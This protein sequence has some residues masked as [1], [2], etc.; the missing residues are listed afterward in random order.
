MSMNNKSLIALDLDGT[1]LKDD[2]TIS[3]KTKTYLK[4]LEEQGNLIVLCSGRALRSVSKYY[5]DIG[6]KVSPIIAYNGHYSTNFH[7][8][9]YEIVHKIDKNTA[10]SLYSNLI[11]G[12]IISAT[13][14]NMHTIYLDKDDPNLFAFYEKDDLKVI[15]GPLDKTIDDDVFTFV[16]KVYK[17]QDKRNRI[18]ETVN[19]LH[20]DICVR[21][22]EG[23]DYAEIYVKGITKATTIE[24]VAKEYN[25][26]FDNIYVFGDADN[27][28]QMLEMYKNSFVMKNG[29]SNLMSIARYI[30]KYTNE[31]DGVYYELKRIFG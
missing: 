19:N 14:E 8:K 21:F 1:L 28:I 24:L 23:D 5:L 15:E 25:I 26:P 6:L 7:D 30:T 10:K 13:S 20:K 4:E 3:L 12:L 18:I 9:K 31:E 22:W 17:D 16:M 29:N 27:D 2:K 11:D